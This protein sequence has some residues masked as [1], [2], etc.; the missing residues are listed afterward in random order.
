MWTEVK[1]EIRSVF[2]ELIIWILQPVIERCRSKDLF[3]LY[4][5]YI[6]YGVIIVLNDYEIFDEQIYEKTLE[7]LSDDTLNVV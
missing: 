7:K 6:I 4:I 1:H 3:T 5:N 2:Y